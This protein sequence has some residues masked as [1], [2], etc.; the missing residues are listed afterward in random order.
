[1]VLI[2]PSRW[3]TLDQHI[4]MAL[5]II[6]WHLQ[7]ISLPNKS[8]RIITSL[9]IIT[10]TN[11]AVRTEQNKMAK[12]GD[13]RWSR[14]K[15]Y[16]LRKQIGRLEI[17]IKQIRFVIFTYQTSL[18][19]IV[20]HHSV[21]N[22]VSP[23][24]WILQLCRWVRELVFK[25]NL[26]RNLSWIKTI[27]RAVC[28]WGREKLSSVLKIRAFSNQTFRPCQMELLEENQSHLCVT[29]PSINQGLTVLHHPI[30]IE[31][32]SNCRSTTES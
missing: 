18:T 3:H 25:D 30:R 29:L 17:K 2:D 4:L 32:P 15:F 14:C 5:K 21:P 24:P 9:N 13:L 8:K 31:L 6:N 7:A 1:M 16:T 27:W 28:I 22:K 23:Y 12:V 19:K 20:I 11:H 26:S 10:R